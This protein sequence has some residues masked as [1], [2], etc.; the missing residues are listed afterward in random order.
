MTEEIMPAG[1]VCTGSRLFARNNDNN[2]HQHPD[3][4]RGQN[5]IQHSSGP[6][7]LTTRQSVLMYVSTSAYG[8]AAY[9]RE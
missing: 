4:R 8:L 5:T 1:S 6:P 2:N 3:S 9:R 7:T